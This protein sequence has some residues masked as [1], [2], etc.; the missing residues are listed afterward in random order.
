MWA[1]ATGVNS[2]LYCSVLLNDNADMTA[3]LTTP[4]ATT[5]PLI[6]VDAS[7]QIALRA[8]R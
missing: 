8:T 4:G 7:S 6:A 5:I 2:D 3:V 1:L